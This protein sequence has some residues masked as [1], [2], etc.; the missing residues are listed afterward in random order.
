MVYNGKEMKI[1]AIKGMS[2]KGKSILD[3]TVKS[4]GVAAGI[5]ALLI[6]I[7]GSPKN[8]MVE[9]FQKSEKLPEPE[10]EKES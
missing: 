5:G 2:E 1:M 7:F 8:C 3:V 9:T 10:N 6:G 4:I